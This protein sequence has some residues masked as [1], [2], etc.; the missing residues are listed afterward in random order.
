MKDS[1]VL[2]NGFLGYI[3]NFQ[4]PNSL[5]KIARAVLVLQFKCE[6]ESDQI[7]ADASCLCYSNIG[8]SVR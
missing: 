1:V 4:L 8:G 7:N 6:P 2:E 3:F 5:M